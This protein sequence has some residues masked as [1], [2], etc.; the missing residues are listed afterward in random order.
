MSLSVFLAV[1]GAAFLHAFWNALVKSGE[2]KV[3]TMLVMTALQG[4]AGLLIALSLPWP[5]T[6]TWVWLAASGIFHAAYKVFLA[7]AYEQGDLSRVYPIARGAAPL[8]V[9]AVSTLFLAAPL[10][11]AEVVGIIVLGLGIVLMGRGAF[12]SGESRRLV[13]LAL[14]SAAATAGYSIVDGM[15]ARVAGDAIL[16]VGWLFALDAAL[17]LP[18]ILVIRGRAVFRVSRAGWTLGAFSAAASYGAYMIAVWAMTV[19]PIALVA[20][21]RETSI[22]FAVLIGWLVFGDRLDRLK[23]GAAA[24]I[25]SGVAA[26]RV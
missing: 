18:V 7:F 1:L 2:S 25:V 22:L 5:T 3:G 14:G 24:L 12:L 11:T 9:L 10:A 16:Y 4:A 15:G 19:A 21:L 8:I 17:F 13:P 23:A 6:E 20:A 26:T